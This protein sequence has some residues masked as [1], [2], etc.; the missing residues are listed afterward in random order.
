MLQKVKSGLDVHESKVHVRS[1]GSGWETTMHYTQRMLHCL[2]STL[3]LFS[4]LWHFILL[5]DVGAAD[6]WGSPAS[7]YHSSLSQWLNDNLLSA[8]S[9]CFHS[10]TTV[11]VFFLLFA[12]TICRSQSDHLSF[13]LCSSCVT[14][15]QKKLVFYKFALHDVKQYEASCERKCVEIDGA[16]A[17]QHVQYHTILYH[18]TV[19]VCLDPRCRKSTRSSE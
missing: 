14:S 3:S 2:D 12:N 15:E 1:T 6:F 5:C 18:F 11:W 17:M 8:C 19:G 4:M 16:L 13:A 7:S 9:P 10:P